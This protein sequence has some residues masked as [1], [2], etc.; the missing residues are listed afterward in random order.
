M[1]MTID[2]P[3]TQTI[4]EQDA[5]TPVFEPQATITIP[6]EEALE[7]FAAVLPHAPK[8]NVTPIICAVRIEDNHL[9]ATDR[10]TVGTFELSTIE[11][12]APFTVPREVAEYI[13]KITAAGL[14]SGKNAAQ[15]YALRITGTPKEVTEYSRTEG[16]TETLVEILPLYFDGKGEFIGT[17]STEHKVERSQAFD[18]LVGN[19]PPVRRLLAGFEEAENATPVSLGPVHL[20]KVT[21]YAK[22]WHKNAA[23][24]FTMSETSNPNKPG[25]VKAEI[26]KLTAL[27]Q[28]NLLLR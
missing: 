4:N 7:A 15:T 19:F 16:T 1:T 25:P 3:A 20:E 2:N 24:R 27:I 21:G 18:G 28:P 23:I 13:V 5:A 17:D 14:R 6:L 9:V 12:H 11:A 22:K 26:G 8:D 10:Y